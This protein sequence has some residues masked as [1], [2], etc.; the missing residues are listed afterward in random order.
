MKN[1]ILLFF[2]FLLFVSV[3]AQEDDRVL[4]RGKV[5][6]RDSNVSNEYV[7]N[8]N[9]EKAVSTNDNGQFETWVKVGDLLVFT[10]VN[11]ELK[12]VVITDA[13]LKNNRL[14]VE[15]NEKVTELD[16]VV[17]SPE[18]QEKF[19]EVKNEEF[20]GY[21]YEIDRTSEVQ[22][23]ALSQTERGMQDGL[24]IKNIF[25][26]LFKAV[27]T[28]EGEER[29]PLK[30]SEVLRT[31]YDDEFFV[32]DLKLPQDKIDAFL[33]YCD[34]KMPSQS[35]LQKDN[36]FQLIDFLVTHSKTYLKELQAEE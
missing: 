8:V 35:L 16:E 14:V 20:K 30:V 23:I 13:I 26:A 1:H 32:M 5:M 24:N 15:V 25:K 31:V 29:P 4:L 6:Y 22:N 27:K 18:N 2:S 9:T 10:A 17:V 3:Q 33:L 34:A 28:E 11:Y 21:E 36:E 7:I 12:S 19:L